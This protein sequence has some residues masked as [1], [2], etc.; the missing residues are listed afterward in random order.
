MTQVNASNYF[1]FGLKIK[2]YTGSSDECIKYG[3]TRVEK[4]L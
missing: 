3:L 1:F 4:Y 2:S